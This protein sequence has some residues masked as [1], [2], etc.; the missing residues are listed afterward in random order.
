MADDVVNVPGL[1]S[2]STK[3]IDS[4]SLAVN[5]LTVLRQRI[6]VSDPSDPNAHAAVITG[7]LVQGVEHYGLFVR[8]ASEQ[9]IGQQA[10]DY[11]T[12]VA[13]VNDFGQI[14][15]LKIDQTTGAGALKIIGYRSS[16][17]LPVEQGNG[18]AP[19]V[20]GWLVET[21]SEGLIGQPPEQNVANLVAG[22]DQSGNIANAQVVNGRILVQGIE[23]ISGAI[24]VIVPQPL[25]VSG[26]VNVGNLVQVS[27]VIANVVSII[28]ATPASGALLHVRVD[29][30]SSGDT[31]LVGGVNG[32]SIRVMRAL[33]TVF[34]SGSNLDIV[35][36]KDTT[37]QNLSGP[38]YFMGLGGITLDD[39][40]EPW[41]VTAVGKGLVLSQT[42]ICAI[43][44]DI[45]YTQS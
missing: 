31:V 27:G 36:W 15:T 12:V 20:F 1:Q 3:A 33:L 29:V 7:A 16:G 11:N 21:A 6:N 18:S 8:G 39:S 32:Q 38:L 19:D 25:G 14:S 43:G 34:A 35:S 28:P 10:P 17:A 9:H 45:W 30:Q 44:G 2:A 40:G 24:N 42:Q 22:L 5:A 26:T 41:W 37:P 23:S 13:G 4:S